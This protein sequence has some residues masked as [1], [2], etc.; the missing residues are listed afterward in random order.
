M[1]SR[2]T[3]VS[4]KCSKNILCKW[5]TFQENIWASKDYEKQQMDRKIYRAA[6]YRNRK[7]KSIHH[8]SNT[9]C[10]QIDARPLKDKAFKDYLKYTL[11]EIAILQP[12][13]II[14]FGNQVSSIFLDKPIKVSNYKNNENDTRIID[15]KTYKIYPDFYPVGQG[16]RNIPAAIVRIQSIIK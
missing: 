6:L 14:I 10:T 8:Q 15:K 12:K 2:T 4:Q 3:T 11:E 5:N 7:E 13:H 1:N 16:M 9:K